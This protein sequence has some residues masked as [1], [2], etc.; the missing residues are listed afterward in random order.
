M[1]EIS[2]ITTCLNEGKNIEKLI[3]EIRF[4]LKNVKHEIIVVDAGSSD[5]TFSV[6]KKLADFAISIKGISQSEGLFYGM[7]SAK[8]SSIITID[9]DLEN[10]PELI[11]MLVERLK[12]YDIV[13]ASRIKIPRISEKL[14]SLTLG[15]DI[16]ISDFYSNFRAYRKKVIKRIK[17]EIGESFGGEFLIKAKEIGLKISEILFKP[18]FR[19]KNPRI[20]GKIKANIRL[21]FVTLKL[22]LI[23]LKFKFE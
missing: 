8:Y 19:R 23:K 14:A 13:V 20:G 4:T 12:D 18:P 21:L 22:F 11:P 5:R 6:A 2:V 17:P 1:R 3:R 7:M 16:G 15:K 10:P 9:C